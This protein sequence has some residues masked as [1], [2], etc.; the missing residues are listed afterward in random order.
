MPKGTSTEACMPSPNREELEAFTRAHGQA[1]IQFSH[2][3]QVPVRTAG[4]WS[5]TSAAQERPGR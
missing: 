1:S 3:C 5:E 4:H 2:H